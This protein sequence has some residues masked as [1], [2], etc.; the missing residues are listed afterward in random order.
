MV[1]S[2]APLDAHRQCGGP[3]RRRQHK[4]CIEK[5]KRIFEKPALEHKFSGRLRLFLI[6]ISPF[7]HAVLAMID[8]SNYPSHP[9][10]AHARWLI[11]SQLEWGRRHVV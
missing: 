5:F 11:D 2:A 7:F 1:A 6:L 4:R 3:L 10:A 9:A 8:S